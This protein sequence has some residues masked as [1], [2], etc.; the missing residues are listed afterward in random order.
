ME[1]CYEDSFVQFRRFS[2]QIIIFDIF[3]QIFCFVLAV[4]LIYLDQ[5]VTKDV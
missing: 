2:V 4:L 1:V 5:Y 3:T